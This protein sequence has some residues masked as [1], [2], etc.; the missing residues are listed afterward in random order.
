[1]K[2]EQAIPN[3]KQ[4]VPYFQAIFSA[5]SHRVSGY[6]VLGRLQTDQGVQ[7]LGPFFHDPGIPERFKMETDLHL[8]TA[9]FETF[10]TAR[11]DVSLYINMNANHLILDRDGF[12]VD[13]KGKIGRAHV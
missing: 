9:A 3:L 8:Q 4:V 11:E 1:M 12:H 6:E 5:D 7:S 2:I 13:E 10:L